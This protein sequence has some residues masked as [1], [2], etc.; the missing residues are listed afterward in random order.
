MGYLPDTNALVA[1]LD[2]PRGPVAKRMRKVGSEPVFLSA[3]VLHELCFGAFRSARAEANLAVVESLRLPLAEFGRED[4]LRAAELRAALVARGTPIGP[5][6][7]LIA[8]QALARGLVVVSNNTREFR[9]V[10]DLRVE[11]WSLP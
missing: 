4:A 6:D 1:V 9:R 10:P 8:G 7:V 11:D 2:D 5:L 3:V